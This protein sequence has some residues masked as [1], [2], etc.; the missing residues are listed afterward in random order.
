MKKNYLR[1]LY[2]GI[3]V[4][5]IVSCSRTDST[6]ML[7]NEKPINSNSVANKTE[8]ELLAKGWT[9][10]KEID[11]MPD[12]KKSLKISTSAKS[13]EQSEL[14]IPFTE[15]YLSQMGWDL[16][17]RNDTNEI[18]K[19]LKSLTPGGENPYPFGVI[20]TP[21]FALNTNP[22]NERNWWKANTYVILGTPELIANPNQ[23][24]LPDEVFATEVT[25]SSNEDSEITVTYSYKTGYR[26]FWNTKWSGSVKVSTSIGFKVEVLAEAKVNVE[27]MVGGEKSYGEDIT[28]EKTLTSTYRT[29]V[30]ANSKKS[31][32]VFTKISGSE[33]NYKVPIT[34]NGTYVLCTEGYKYEINSRD[35][36][37][38]LLRDSSIPMD[39]EGIVKAI[40]N[41]T[42]KILE[43]P[44]VKL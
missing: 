43:S 21:S 32:R 11:L 26:Y 44:A 25:N 29:K 16:S 39:E 13:M 6:G 31:I 15:K 42:I 28:Q 5:S 12:L 19:Q 24:E 4:L 20:F 41:T 40:A 14:K 7:E 18:T 22:K 37:R 9:M 38:G 8:K 35:I 10:V 17:N 30:P 3:T 33:V 1:S 36:T 34:V 27:V 2:V 23:I